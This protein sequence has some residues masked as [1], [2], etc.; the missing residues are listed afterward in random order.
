MGRGWRAGSSAVVPRAVA[1]LAVIGGVAACGGDDDDGAETVR[2][3]SVLRAELAD[4]AAA[5]APGQHLYL[6]DVT[7]GPDTRLSTHYHDGIQIAPCT[8]PYL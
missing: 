7:I 4:A 6:Q 5:N 1:V 2:A 8:C 3:G